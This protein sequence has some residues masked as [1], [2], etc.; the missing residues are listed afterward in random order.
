MQ[1]HIEGALGLR[2]CS[3]TMAVAMGADRKITC[4]L[5]LAE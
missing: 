1:V 3:H 4:K 2:L 5:H